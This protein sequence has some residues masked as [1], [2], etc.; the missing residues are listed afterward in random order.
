MPVD[1]VLHVLGRHLLGDLR[2]ARRYR[3]HGAAPCLCRYTAEHA[4]GPPTTVVAHF[5]RH[6]ALRGDRSAADSPARHRPHDPEHDVWAGHRHGL[7]YI[8]GGGRAAIWA[9]AARQLRR[10]GAQGGVDMKRRSIP[11]VVANKEQIKRY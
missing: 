9:V 2:A 5:C 11:H 7:H 6:G 4:A 8:Y 10:P 1:T 3:L